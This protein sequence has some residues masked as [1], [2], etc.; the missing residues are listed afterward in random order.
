MGKQRR[1]RGDRPAWEA[2]PP[3]DPEG[4]A[5]SDALVTPSV[6]T[7]NAL[8]AQVPAQMPDV[9][10]APAGVEA[11]ASDIISHVS[12]AAPS[13]DPAPAP[14]EIRA[15]A[16]T[17]ATV[18]PDRQAVPA[19]MQDPVALA[20]DRFDMV[21]IGSTIAR[22][23]RGEGEAALAHV[24]ALTDAR[25]PADLIRLQVGEVQRAADASLSCWVT[26]LGKASRLVA[27]R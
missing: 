26:V 4:T 18:E 6:E 8:P 1:P 23:M 7:P 11:I 16:P 14:A 12:V 21:E 10:P 13:D 3:L 22:Y 17:T 25:T 15:P 27:F 24:R 20:P 9:V 5:L 19:P 2:R